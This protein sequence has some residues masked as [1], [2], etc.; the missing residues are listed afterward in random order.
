MDMRVRHDFPI[1]KQE[2]NGHPLIYFDT[3]ATAQKPLPVI[4]A[5][6]SFMREHYGT[7][8][9][10]VYSLAV[11]ATEAY[12]KVRREVQKLLNAKE[13]HEIIFTRGATES[14]NMAAYSFGKAFIKPG[15]EIVITEM[16][17]HSN[18]VPWQILCQDRAAR[19]KVV[20]FDDAG[21]LDMEE[22][23]KLVTEK[24]KLVAVTHVSNTLGTVNPMK[25][26][27][28]IAHDAGAKVLVDGAQ[29]TPHMAIDVQDLDADFYI[30]SG[31]KTY[32]PTGI[33]ILYGKEE[34]LD[35]M[36]PYQG[37]GDMIKK[38]T[39]EKTTY[40]DLPL[41]FEAGTP[42]IVEV[43]GLGAAIRYLQ[44]IG[45]EAIHAYEQDLLKHLT[46]K[47]TSIDGMNIFGT[48]KGKGAVVS[49]LI[50][51]VHPLDLGTLL[52]LRGI[53][54][55]TGH[56]CTQP[57]M[58]HYNIDATARVSLG[59]YNTKEEIDIFHDALLAAVGQLR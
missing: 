40:N 48:A 11:E 35:Q 39:F 53:A 22:F 27:I 6:D 26:I 5:M 19:L 56:H 1:L 24:T 41:K 47:L 34:L 4:E 3:A 17:H 31:H 44:G 29:A 2:F 14:I 9:R 50:D 32:G 49:F 43:I 58:Q 55:R 54:I 13:P 45:M 23:R 42:M 30:F 20:P 10:A 7:V 57:I 59:M 33:G 18:I 37:G 15:D 16:E 51:G 12:Q 46:K 21:N 28:A 36:P 25:E 52:D 38:V 8:H